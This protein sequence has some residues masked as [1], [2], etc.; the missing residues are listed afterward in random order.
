MHCQLH[1]ADAGTAKRCTTAGV[2][3]GAGFS[4]L[5]KYVRPRSGVIAQVETAGKLRLATNL[6]ATV[7]AVIEVTAAIIT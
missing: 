7:S 1:K 6:S 2:D 3:A 4:R 5:G